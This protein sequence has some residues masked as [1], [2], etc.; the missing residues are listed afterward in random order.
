MLFLFITTGCIEFLL[1]R[2]K[3]DEDTSSIEPITYEEYPIEIS[4]EPSTEPSSPTSEPSASQPA[5]EPSS[6]QPTSEPSSYPQPTSEPSSYPQPTSEPAAQPSYEPPGSTQDNPDSAY[7]GDVVIN[8]IMINPSGSDSDREWIELWNT[9]DLWLS[10]QNYR[11]KD[12]G[13]DDVELTPTST[14]SL[15]VPPGGYILICSNDN[16]WSNG[17]V[18]CNATFLSQCFGGGYCLSNGE[19]EV[20]LATASGLVI[21]QIN[22][23]EGFSIEGESMGL[24]PDKATPQENDSH[25]NWCEQWGFMA[26]GDN[27]NPGEE[28]DQC[29]GVY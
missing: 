5:S 25:S 24:D 8:E 29:W 26:Q 7:Y 12:N 1:Y 21:D 15:I 4:T 11:L 3:G 27:G 9:T 17:G 19:D 13:V 18:N 6:S 14:N 10:L 22:Y 16:Y 28:N 20:I 23:Q 2:I